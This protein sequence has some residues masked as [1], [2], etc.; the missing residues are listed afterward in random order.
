[1][2]Y[3]HLK[4]LWLADGSKTPLKKSELLISEE[5]NISAVGAGN[6]GSAAGAVIDLGGCVAAPGFIDVHGHS[7][8]AIAALPGAFGRVSQGVTCEIAGNCGLSAFPLTENNREHLEK[9]YSKYQ[10]NLNWQSFQEYAAFIKSRAPFCDVEALTGH[11]TLRAA[12]SG[13]GKSELDENALFTACRLLDESLNS[14]SCGLSLGLLYVPGKFAADEEL[15]ALFSTVARHGK[16]VT[17][18]LKSEGKMLCES[19][20]DM[21]RIS[22]QS[23]LKK[24]HISH[25]KTSGRENFSKLDQALELISDAGKDGISVTFDRYPYTQ[26]MT[27]LSLVLPDEWSDVDDVTITEQLQDNGIFRSVLDELHTLRDEKY[28]QS[29]LLV[30]TP[31]P[32]YAGMRGAPLAALGKDPALAVLEI[33][34]YDSPQSTAAF[35]GMSKDNMVK[36]ICDPRC[37]P[38]RD[39]TALDPDGSFGTDHPRSFGAVAKFIRLLLDNNISIPESVHRAT[40]LAAST[41]DL[42]G[43]GAIT[44]GAAADIT[45]FD[46]EEIDGKASFASPFTPASGIKLVFKNGNIVY[47]YS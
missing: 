42:A 47:R 39:G 5:G 18:H 13:Y 2:R 16:T 4:N 11:N 44:C 25:F 10:T 41:F 37:M 3:W 23:G 22:R 7:D 34:R 24:F 29:V 45:V 19:I 26:S 12:V 32:G 46:P 33:L 14:G 30:N 31:H 17:C 6:I 21:L 40:G 43:R 27:Q 15:T 38:G 36:I 9:L 28:W 8:L 1:M 35:S 20:S